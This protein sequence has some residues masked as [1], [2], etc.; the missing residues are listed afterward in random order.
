MK[1]S[2]FNSAIDADSFRMLALGFRQVE[3][4][5]LLFRAKRQ[6]GCALELAG[7]RY[8]DG[9]TVSLSGDL[10]GGEPLV[11]ALLAK[12]VSSESFARIRDAKS[13][14]DTVSAVVD[15]LNQNLDSILVAP[16]PVLHR[17]RV[18]LDAAMEQAQLETESPVFCANKSLSWIE[19]IR[20]FL[21]R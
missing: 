18:E 11:L 4:S 2:D 19:R 13:P 8:G 20:R 16:E 1:T 3:R 14:R 7:E 5:G 21:R 17:Y 9:M 6:D 10:S 12:A 15:F